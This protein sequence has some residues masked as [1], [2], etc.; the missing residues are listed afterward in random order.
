MAETIRIAITDWEETGK[1]VSVVETD[2]DPTIKWIVI[3]NP[4]GSDI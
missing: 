1:L 2:E 3:L 4:D